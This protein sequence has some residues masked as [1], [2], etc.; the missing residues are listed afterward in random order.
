MTTFIILS[1]MS[2][3]NI[4]RLLLGVMM[5]LA[6]V[7]ADAQNKRRGFVPE[8]FQADLEQYITRKACLTPKEA[9]KF[10]PVYRE[11]RR[12]QHAVHKE[13][14][15]L[16]RVKPVTDAECEKNIMMRDK[17]QIEIKEIEKEYHY[18]FLQ[19]LPAKKVYNVLRAEDR[20]HRQMF[21]R[22][23]NRNFRKK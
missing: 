10:F 18:K 23:A 22:A 13:L 6:V 2:E 20:F 16:K 12:K 14:K 9:S 21:K 8:R 7:G 19:M 1:Q 11:M 17:Y 15:G 4:K 5:L 3:M